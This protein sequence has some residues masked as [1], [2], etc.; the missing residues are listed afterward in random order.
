MTTGG[1]REKLN[2]KVGITFFHNSFNT[3]LI[4]W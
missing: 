2:M 3:V 1:S 4:I